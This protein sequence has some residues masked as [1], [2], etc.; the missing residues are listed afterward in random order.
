MK[1]RSPSTPKKRPKSKPAPRPASYHWAPYALLAI[2][3]LFTTYVRLRYLQLPLERD[4]GEF[5]YIAQC[6]LKG[7]SPFEAYNYK[8]PGVPYFYAAFMAVFGQ[9]AAAIHLA[10]LGANLTTSL[11]LFF[12]AGRF[13]GRFYAAAAAI[14]Y[15]LLSLDFTVLGTAAHATQFVN[16]FV[17]AASFFLLREKPGKWSSLLV[18]LLMGAAFIMKQPAFLFIIFG[19]AFLLV[20]QAKDKSGNRASVLA[21]ELIFGLGA[22]VPYS[23]VV[24]I[25]LANHQFDRFWKWTVTYPGYYVSSLPAARGWDN[26]AIVFGEIVDRFPLLWYLAGFGLVACILNS[27]NRWAYRIFLPMLCIISVTAIIPGYYFHHHYFLLLLPAV[28][29]CVGCAFEM[30]TRLLGRFTASAWLVSPVISI[31]IAVSGIWAQ[32]DFYFKYSTDEYSLFRYANNPFRE[33]LVLSDYIRSITSENDKILVV[34]SEAEIY[35]YSQRA[36]ASGY[37]FVHGMVSNQPANQE[38]QQEFIAESEASRPEVIVFCGVQFSWLKQPGTPDTVL[39]WFGPYVRANYEIK[40][41]ADMMDQGTIYK[42]EDE[43][44]TYMPQAVNYLVVYKRR[45]A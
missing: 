27:E 24:L 18:G 5:G 45:K 12:A 13:L 32:K 33:A 19:A 22:A 8:L 1:K 3:L 41:I 28:S 11:L 4:E 15:S 23:L 20:A 38:M 35:Y 2:G 10:L 30:L 6:I 36:A 40:G 14:T 44:K 21:H 7:L 29:L 42:W 26:F 43:A 37:L 31:L 17:A 34:G 16:L 9:T 25:A 39:Q